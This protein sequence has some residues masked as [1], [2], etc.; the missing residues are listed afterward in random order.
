MAKKPN[1]QF[2]PKLTI[3]DFRLKRGKLTISKVVD[4]D[5][6]TGTL[7]TRRW[8]FFHIATQETVR[9]AGINAPEL[10]IHVNKGPE[11][12]A[13]EA[14]SYLKKWEGK[15]VRVKFAVSK[16]G[17]W[18]RE[19]QANWG[20]RLPGILYPHVWSA[21]SINARLVDRGLARLYNKPD[22]MTK[23]LAKELVTA[24]TQARR[25]RRGLWKNVEVETVGISV[26]EAVLYCVL[27]FALGVLIGA[28]L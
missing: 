4:G 10:N 13:V 20:P 6:V 7:R 9:L 19:I 17:D 22:W 14:S 16:G 27:C 12:Y 18:L 28:A 23:D 3:K 1:D 15:N 8:L 26:G 21:R 24:W 25:H 11:N 5:T 2:N